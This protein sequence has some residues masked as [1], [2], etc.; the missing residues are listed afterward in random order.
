MKDIFEKLRYHH[1]N[2]VVE[3]KKAENNFDFDD[4]G[5]YYSAL[6]NEANLRSLDK[7]WL[8]FGVHDKTRDIV[9]T[10]YCNSEKNLQKLKQRLSQN[11]TNKVT[12]REIYDITV[13]G[14]R[15]LMFQIPAAPRGV[16]IAW[17]GHYYARR[18]E[19]LTALDM[20]QYDEI[21]S[22]AVNAD[23]SKEIVPQATIGD[24]DEEAIAEARKGY[25]E[26]V[27]SKIAREVDQ[28]DTKTFLD[29]ARLTINGQI[30]RTALLLLGK[31]ESTHLLNH[32][33][34][35]IW[36]LE[37]KEN[38]G[39]V[40]GIPFL[41][42]TTQVLHKIR[43]YPFKIYP[44]NSLIP[45]EGMKYD[46]ESILEA[47]H[48]CI[49]HQDYT[50][51]ARIILIE[52]GE[53]LEFSNRG[54]FYA[55]S[56]DDYISGEVVPDRYRNQFLVQAMVNIKMIDSQ[57]FGIHK[58][59]LKQKERFLP[60]PDYDKSDSNHVVLRI[61]GTVI[62]ENYSLMLIENKELDL[63]TTVLLDKVQKGKSISDSAVK[64][65]RKRK[66]IEGRKPHLFVSKSIAQATHKEIEYTLV[67]GFDDTECEAWIKKALKQH[68]VLTR[69]QVNELLWHKLPANYDEDRKNNK[70]GNLLTKFRKKG[71]IIC[72][73][74]KKW[75]LSEI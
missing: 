9:G 4:L 21:R 44:Q 45:S 26:H 70:I 15:V 25:K 58:L 38:V 69:K 68:G 59:Y 55:G 35:I 57:G 40:F 39:Q 47:I 2:E 50:Q 32:I 37:G 74:Q 31:I 53:E 30:T 54:S 6:S 10:D 20:G 64:L 52:R 49:A 7:A 75:R 73:S 65:L 5:K 42:S 67:K 27:S 63:A 72:D 28:W 13:E 12:F 17:N 8:V 14:K 24:L 33:G 62:N 71:L 46:E 66:L 56:P 1:E 48:N 23:W 41:L 43:N 51:N 34:E 60:M 61:P 3:F 22:Q 19:S 36:R 18:G 16:P 29:K 11:T